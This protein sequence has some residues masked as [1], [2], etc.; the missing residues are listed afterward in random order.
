MI[1]FFSQR[2]ELLGLGLG[3]LL[4]CNRSGLLGNNGSFFGRNLSRLLERSLDSG[5]DVGYGGLL[6]ID[7]GLHGFLDAGFALLLHGSV[8]TGLSLLRLLLL[9]ELALF[10]TFGDSAAHGI[11]HYG[12]RFGGIVICRDNVINVGRITTSVY[13]CKYGD[14]QALGLFYRI[15]L[16][17]YVNDEQGGRKAR[18]VGDG[19]EV[20]LKFRAW[21]AIWS[22]SRLEKLSNVPSL[23]ILS[24]VDIFLTALRMVGKFVS[25]P[26]AQRSVT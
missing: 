20:L 9:F 14:A 19:T 1:N 12:N 11:E 16:L 3:N 22:F 2:P 7:S 18:Q 26:P 10:G 21:R 6:G 4:G 5:Y 8:G 15:R 23:F 13:H 25:I 24:M 17:L